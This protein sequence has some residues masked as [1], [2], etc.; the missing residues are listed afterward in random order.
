[1]VAGHRPRNLFPMFPIDP[2]KKNDV[3]TK[4]G[5]VK[6]ERSWIPRIKWGIPTIT[7]A[8]VCMYIHTYVRMYVCKGGRLD[9][10]YDLRAIINFIKKKII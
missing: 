10:Y 4:K 6:F 8:Y 5:G 7:V 3:P 9:D 2:C 1:M